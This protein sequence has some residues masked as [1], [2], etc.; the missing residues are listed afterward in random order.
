MKTITIPTLLLFLII[1][2]FIIIFIIVEQL[3]YL[4]VILKNVQSDLS[5]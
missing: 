1:L 5:V 4:T 3:F 2:T